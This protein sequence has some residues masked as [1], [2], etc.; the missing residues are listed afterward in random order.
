MACSREKFAFIRGEVALVCPWDKASPADGQLYLLRPLE[1]PALFS[2][3]EDGDVALWTAVASLIRAQLI[4]SS[5]CPSKINEVVKNRANWHPFV[6]T[7]TKYLELLSNGIFGPEESDLFSLLECIV[8]H[9]QILNC[10]QTK[11]VGLK[12][13]ITR[14]NVPEVISYKEANQCSK[15]A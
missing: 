14:V 5:L 8:A 1:R 9:F 13:R 11:S 4:I 10:A 2:L 15:R 6:N 3:P 12:I 7:T